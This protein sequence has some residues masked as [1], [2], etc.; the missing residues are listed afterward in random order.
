MNYKIKT[1]RSI[2]KEF[3]RLRKHYAALVDDY[4]RL[5]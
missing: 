1:A 2:E 3:K 4:N 5:K